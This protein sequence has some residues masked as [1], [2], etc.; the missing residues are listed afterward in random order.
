MFASP[1]LVAQIETLIVET[2]TNRDSFLDFMEAASVDGIQ[3]KHVPKALNA[4]TAKRR[5]MAQNEGGRS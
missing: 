3:A 1:D 4:L 2:K 5:K